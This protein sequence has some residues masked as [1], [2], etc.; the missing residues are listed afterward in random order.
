MFGEKC[1]PKVL[2]NV[3]ESCRRLHSLKFAEL[4]R[5]FCDN[6]TD[7]GFSFSAQ[8]QIP[9]LYIAHLTLGQCRAIAKKCARADC[10]VACACSEL[11]EVI[12]GLSGH[13]VSLY[14]F[15]EDIGDLPDF[16]A[17]ASKCTRLA[18]VE[19]FVEGDSESNGR[20]FLQTVLQEVEVSLYTLKI[21]TEWLTIYEHLH[22]PLMKTICD[23]S[24]ID[25]TLRKL[26]IIGENARIYEELG[27]AC[28]FLESVVM[29]FFSRTSNFV[30]T[31]LACF[32]VVTT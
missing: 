13:L 19:W 3:K 24:G 16:T 22:S 10:S 21:E 9:G 7:L 27:E 6:L 14:V 18:E 31:L 30:L 28:A 32:P 26:E 17:S 15:G 8:L 20:V 4:N 29:R 2:L 25:G 11:V 12:K 5:A 23:T 1:S